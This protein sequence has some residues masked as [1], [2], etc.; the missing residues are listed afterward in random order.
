MYT[1]MYKTDGQW[2]PAVGHRELSLVLCYDFDGWVG[3]SRW[4]GSSRERGLICIQLIHA[5][6]QH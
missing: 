1:A 6:V 3:G 4:E 2:H 5:A